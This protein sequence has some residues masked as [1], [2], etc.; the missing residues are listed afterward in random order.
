MGIGSGLIL[1]FKSCELYMWEI[2]REEE[3][4]ERRKKERAKS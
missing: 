2:L 4:N 3:E 1:R